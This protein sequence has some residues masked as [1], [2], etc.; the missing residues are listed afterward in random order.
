MLS[1]LRHEGAQ[2]VQQSQLV[3]HEDSVS[4]GSPAELVRSLFSEA[5]GLGNEYDQ[6]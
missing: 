3:K 5:A 4:L 6:M 1:I 2:N